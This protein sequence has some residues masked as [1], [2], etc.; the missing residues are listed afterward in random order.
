M[1]DHSK[2]FIASSSLDTVLVVLEYGRW[3]IGVRSLC[4]WSAVVVSLE[5]GRQVAGIRFFWT[6]NA[7]LFFLAYN[8]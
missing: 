8:E 3:N 7:V 1:N 4:R 6:W 5:C 2:A